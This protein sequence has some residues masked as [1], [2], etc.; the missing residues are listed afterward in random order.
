M[1]DNPSVAIEYYVQGT[2]NIDEIFRQ[3]QNEF[4]LV[5]SSAMDLQLK[6]VNDGYAMAL[7]DIDH[8]NWAQWRSS[9][10]AFTTEPAAIVVNRAAFDGLTIP[11]TRQD[12]ILALRARPEVFR[13][14]LATYD[15]RTSGLGYLFAT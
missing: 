14:K 15:V 11:K 10:F 4:D 13:N 3:S 2:A 12:L 7:P 1:G 6:L 9:L 5:I 8:A